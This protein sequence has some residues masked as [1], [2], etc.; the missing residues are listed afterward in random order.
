MGQILLG[1]ISEKF[2][3]AKFSDRFL[4]A[5]REVCTRAR[6]SSTFRVCDRARL[7]RFLRPAWWRGMP[8]RE[9]VCG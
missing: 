4:T 3:E 6:A 1:Q 8:A 5:F 2:V 7:L 9:S